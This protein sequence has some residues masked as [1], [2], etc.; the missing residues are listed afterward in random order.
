VVRGRRSGRPW[1]EN[2]S[3]RQRRRR[4]RRKRREEEEEE[5]DDGESACLG[6]STKR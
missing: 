4:R 3:N 6:V 2:A 1:R 5:E